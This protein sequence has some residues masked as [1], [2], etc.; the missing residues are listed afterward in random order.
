[1]SITQKGRYR[2]T[3]PNTKEV[4]EHN[5]HDKAYDKAIEIG[6]DWI[7]PPQGWEV[8]GFKLKTTINA[9]PTVDS[10]PAPSSFT[11]G[12]A[13]TYDMTQHFT[14][15]G[16]TE[17]I[18]AMINSLGAGLTFNT[19]TGLLSYD[20]VGA[21]SSNQHQ[22]QVDDQ[23]NPVVTSNS[24]TIAIVE[25]ASLI[26]VVTFDDVP[27]GSNASDLPYLARS[28]NEPVIVG[29]DRGVT[30]RKTTQMMMSEL[31]RTSSGNNFRTEVSVGEASTEYFTGVE[32]WVGIS[33]FLPSDWSLDY[34]N[35]FINKQGDG[36]LWQFHSRE[37]S[38]IRAI[39]PLILRHK[40]TGFTIQNQDFPS[41]EPQATIGKGSLLNI[42]VNVPFNL[43][44]WMD[45][46]MNVQFSGSEANPDDTNG[47]VRLW[48][49]GVLK[50]DV[51]GQ[52]YFGEGRGPFLKFGVYN[53]AWD[54]TSAP[55]TGAT[56]RRLYHDELRVGDAGSGYAAV[57]PDNDPEP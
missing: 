8:M 15:D 32:F 28:G 33:V 41:A 1:M 20:G 49:D 29:V 6:A 10:T 35:E 56:F 51:A 7:Y 17:L 37:S 24:F 50:I 31:D 55:F 38:T 57:H 42:K 27:I 45:F 5:R 46:V 53:S 16:V 44:S 21:V 22:V 19:S 25:P 12:T 48:V 2:V 9:Q 36:I 11:Q 43:G 52:T 39:L 23:V 26:Q 40:E 13:G 18:W 34:G 54:N 4:H 30:P 14:D 47:F 3:D